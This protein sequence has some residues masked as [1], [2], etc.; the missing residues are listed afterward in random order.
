MR[1]DNHSETSMNIANE[2]P[3]AIIGGP[4]V[5]LFGHCTT[6]ILVRRGGFQSINTVPPCRTS[7]GSSV[8]FGR[9][10]QR[11]AQCGTIG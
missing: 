8:K 7:L 5:P 4:W 11:T 2:A 6:T 10:R 1:K 9:P 3:C